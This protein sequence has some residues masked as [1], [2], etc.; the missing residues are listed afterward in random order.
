MVA[1]T[2]DWCLCQFGLHSAKFIIMHL[3]QSDF[4]STG[5]WYGK[6]YI[7]YAIAIFIIYVF[8]KTHFMSFL[9]YFSHKKGMENELIGKW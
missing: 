9:M 5:R 6:K 4:L 2:I 3:N 8:K 1:Q 7:L